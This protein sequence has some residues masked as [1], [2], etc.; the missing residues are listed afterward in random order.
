MAIWH[1]KG[2]G[3]L[4]DYVTVPGLSHAL[5]YDWRG[6]NAGPPTS[7]SEVKSSFDT[8]RKAFPGAKVIASTLD[9]FASELEKVK[10]ALP[11]VTGE[12]GDSWI[13]GVGSDPVKTQMMRAINRQ[14]TAC[15][16]SGSCPPAGAPAAENP[17]V[18]NM[19]RLLVKGSE[20]T[21]GISVNTFGSF[22]NKGWSNVKFHKNRL[23]G[24]GFI[25]Q[26]EQE[27][28]SQYA[29]AVDLPLDALATSASS[30]AKVIRGGVAEEQAAL[31]PKSADPAAEGFQKVGSNSVLSRLGGW[32]DFGV[33]A[34]SGAVTTLV[35][36]GSE[37]QGV[38]WASPSRPLGLQRYQSLTEVDYAAWRK[39]YL[40]S[41]CN[42][43]YGKPG[44]DSEE[45][46]KSKHQVLPPSVSALWVRNSTV[47]SAEVLMQ[48]AFP[49]ALNRDYGAPAGAWVR[50]T[51][52][53]GSAELDRGISMSVSYLNKTSTRLGEAMFVTMNPPEGDD[54]VRSW[55]AVDKH[56]QW[57]SPLE[58]VDGAPKGLH[59]LTTGVKYA[60]M[61]A[62]GTQRHVFFESK[63]AAMVAFD[64]PTPFPTPIHDQPNLAE[65]ASFL[66]WDNIWNT[67]YIFW[68]PYDTPA[69]QTSADIAFRFAVRFLT[70]TPSP[71]PPAPSHVPT[72]APTP[73]VEFNDM[74]VV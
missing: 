35:D 58:L 30:A 41:D 32:C 53:Q 24:E 31:A 39:T 56:S 8:V 70:T 72:P 60:R 44:Q 29:F 52:E 1:P 26:Y 7:V 12:I 43:E 21:W 2:Y 22:Q 11:L 34:A 18:Y 64:S 25:Q 47:G 13:W 23:D 40:I 49:E 62:D 67:N 16:A 33:D 37:P 17:A 54:T 42:W 46:W 19:S 10:D 59:G 66:L 3:G 27:W 74:L 51:F 15:I 65:G 4:G 9:A 6:D 5:A 71:P 55:W 20:H 14:R 57:V 36:Y 63:D 69:E 48:L 61:A 38:A 50:F 28:K 68:W 45:G 73:D